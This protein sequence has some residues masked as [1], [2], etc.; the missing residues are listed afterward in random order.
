[1]IKNITL[2]N[3]KIPAFFFFTLFLIS[4]ILWSSFGY[5]PTAPIIIFTVFWLVMLFL[6]KEISIQIALI[7]ITLFLIGHLNYQN[8][9]QT[10]DIFYEKMKNKKLE[11]IA[12]VK[13]IKNQENI[14]TPFCITVLTQKIKVQDTK[15]WNFKNKNIC[16]YLKTFPNI[17]IGDTIKIEN[18][19]IKKPKNK[20]F[21][22]YLIKQQI[23][24]TIFAT[25]LECNLLQRPKHSVARYLHEKKEMLLFSLKKKMSPQ[26]FSLF[27][28]VFLGNKSFYKKKSQELKNKFKAW[29]ILHILAR[30][31]LHLIIFL[32]L[33]ELLLKIIPICFYIKQIIMLLLSIVYLL[34]SWPSISFIRAFSALIIY[35][36]CP[37]LKTKPDLL[38]ILAAICTTM[39]IFNPIQ[40]FFLDFQL[41]F[42]L[43]L[44]LAL[45]NKIEIRKKR[46]SI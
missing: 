45:L 19:T 1:M 30:S 24:A 26:L 29:G 16:F 44:T 20:K 21:V 5:P 33:C 42:S 41:S 18:I 6:K 22:A 35:K 8:Q 15:P 17:K 7:A 36:I 13:N 31:G 28:S 32:L 40:L 39:L 46:R 10:H 11:I 12:T 27:S 43:T 2:F 4:G 3:T 9:I 25:K 14:R 37:F 34:L 23:S 38:Y